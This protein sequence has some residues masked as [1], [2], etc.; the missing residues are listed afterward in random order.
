VPWSNGINDLHASILFSGVHICISVQVG[1]DIACTKGTFASH[2]TAMTIQG[3]ASTLPISNVGI[4]ALFATFSAG[5]ARH[6][7]HFFR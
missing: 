3:Q 4:P 6:F 7:R 2:L 1:E 5:K